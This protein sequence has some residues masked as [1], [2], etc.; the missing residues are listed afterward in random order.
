PFVQ[1]RKRDLKADPP[2]D[3]GA[4]QDDLSRVMTLFAHH[5]RA[6]PHHIDGDGLCR[7]LER[8]EFCASCFIIHGRSLDHPRPQGSRKISRTAPWRWRAV[9]RST[10][11]PA[12]RL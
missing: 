5:R 9:Q 3:E 7:I 4:L 2:G 10:M 11:P 6:V 12:P 8:E 1:I